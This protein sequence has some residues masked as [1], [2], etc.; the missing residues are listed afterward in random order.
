MNV[1]GL[2]EIAE[3]I[4]IRRGRYENRPR[5]VVIREIRT[6]IDRLYEVDVDKC[7]ETMRKVR[8]MLQILK[9]VIDKT[10]EML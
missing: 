5:D 4:E 6:F 8:D 3:T 10:E 9:V 7:I 2:C 1:K